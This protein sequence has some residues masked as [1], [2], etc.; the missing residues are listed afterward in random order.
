MGL[1]QI[2]GVW[3]HSTESDPQQEIDVNVMH[4]DH[5]R[6]WLDGL[7]TYDNPITHKGSYVGEV[8]LLPDSASQF[9]SEQLC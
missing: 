3:S 7:K 9:C 5:I 4:I 1:S 8:P 2:K 6:D